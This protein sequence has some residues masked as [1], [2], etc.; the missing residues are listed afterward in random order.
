[1]IKLFKKADDVDT[2]VESAL[3]LVSVTERSGKFRT[4]LKEFILE[5]VSGPSQYFVRV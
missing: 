4:E 5:G 1:M 2:G 3:R